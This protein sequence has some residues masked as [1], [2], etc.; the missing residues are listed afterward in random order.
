MSNNQ[1]NIN[2]KKICY[3]MIFDIYW[4]DKIDSVGC[5][6]V[7]AMQSIGIDCNHNNYRSILRERNIISPKV[8]F[9][10]P[11]GSGRSF[12]LSPCSKDLITN[13]VSLRNQMAISD[14]DKE[15]W[16][17][18]VIYGCVHGWHGIDEDTGATIN[19]MENKRTI[20]LI[21]HDDVRLF[22]NTGPVDERL[23]LREWLGLQVTNLEI[24][25]EYAGEQPLERPPG[26]VQ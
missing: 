14:D 20:P 19:G 7:K 9:T 1:K 6:I 8:W 10:L 25:R 11:D 23:T 26:A 15:K 13:I 2:H 4:M 18:S 16:L 21:E 12:L 24:F 5:A 3:Q 22:N 17:D